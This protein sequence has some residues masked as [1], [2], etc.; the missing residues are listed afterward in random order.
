MT[1]APRA[2][3]R[4]TRKV[5]TRPMRRARVRRRAPTS[6]PRDV[7]LL[8]RWLRLRR[9]ALF[10]ARG[11]CSFSGE[12]VCPLLGGE[13]PGEPFEVAAECGLEVVGGDTDAMIGDASLREV[14]RADLRRAVTGT[15]LGLAEGAFLLRP[16][17]HLA[18][19]ETGLQ[20]PHGLLLVLELAL[21]VLAGD[22]QARRLVRDSDRGVRGVHALAAGT[23]GTVHVDLEVSRADLDLH[24][25]GLWQDGHGSRRLRPGSTTGYGACSRGGRRSG[26][27]CRG[28]HRRRGP[29]RRRQRRPGSR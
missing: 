10:L 11:S 18:F 23:A 22:D 2:L 1:P 13:G 25:L 17:A 24:V 14:V 27:T 7:R 16:F 29:P 19:Q 8:G 28:A 5:E 15:D 26:Y 12:L 3:C 6:P 20:D 4:V 21:F 9:H